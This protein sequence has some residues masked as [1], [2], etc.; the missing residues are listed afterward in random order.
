MRKFVLLITVVLFANFVSAQSP[1]KNGNLKVSENGRYLQHEN[2]KPFFYLAAT[3]WL[4]FQRMNRDEV[5]Q[6]FE[7]RKTKGFNVVQCIFYQSYND[8]NVH[9]DSAYVNKDLTQPKHT[10]GNDPDNA[11]QYDFWDH[12]DYITEV[13]ANNGIYLAISPTWGQLVLRDKNMTKEKA[14][15]FA[16]HLANHFKD[17][18]NIIWMNGGSAK[19][20]VN[21]EIWETIGSTIKKNDPNHLITFHTFGRTQSSTW[22]Q[23]ASWLDFNMFTSGHRRYDQ[24][25]TPKKYGEDNWR[26]VLEDLSKTQ[27]KPTLDGEPSYESIPQGLHDHTQPYWKAS[28]VR[29]YA[30]WSVF[31]GACGHA[32]GQNTVRQVYKQGINKGESGAKI[33]FYEALEDTGSSQ[34]Q[35]VKKLILSR[36]NFDRVN[37]QSVVAGDEGEKY[38]RILAIRGKGY[39]MAYTYTGR[40]FKIQLG[41]I[42]GTKVNAWWYNPRTGLAAKIGTFN[43]KGIMSFN[44][45]GEKANGNDWVLVLDDVSQKFKAPGVNFYN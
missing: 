23:H 37:D 14:E 45:P 3:G 25:D 8:R 31:A 32:Y 26:Y 20:E 28:D 24:D 34:M 22:F 30:Y 43:N 36:P 10:P 33:S 6:Y 1:W 12:V 27:L 5:K 16:V 13:A 42:S 7:N 9:D 15:L 44:P 38:D 41:I 18:P 4:I 40:N 29:R 19:G 39:L 21:T 35:Y 11:E 2:G 17:R